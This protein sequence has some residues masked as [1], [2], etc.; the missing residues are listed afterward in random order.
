MVPQAGAVTPV[1]QAIV[2][3]TVTVLVPVTEEL[4]CKVVLVMTLEDVGEIFKMTDDVELPPH[5]NAPI[6]VARVTI[7]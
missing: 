5:P 7:K 3:A 6:I 2:Q 4:N 1:A